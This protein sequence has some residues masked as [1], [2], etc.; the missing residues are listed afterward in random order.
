VIALA[1]MLIFWQVPPNVWSGMQPAACIKDGCFCEAANQDSPIKQTAN[2]IS[3]LGF[4]FSGMIVMIR[5]KE[6]SRFPQLYS[7]IIGVSSL[8]IGVGSAFYHA[9]LTFIGQ[10][11]D[12]FGMFL[13]A[14][15]L[16]VYAF[17]RI[18][19]LRITTTL[20]LY[21]TLNL[22]LSWIQIAIPETRRYAFAI[23]LIIALL[24]ERYY[25]SKMKPQIEAKWLRYGIIILAVAY[26]IWIADNTRMI[27]FEH[28]I[29]QGH[30]IWHILGAVSVL[31][32]H[33]YY[34]SER[35]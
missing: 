17:E 34:V 16:L 12:V 22:I 9:S 21:L 19:N 2:T 28:S 26:I 25:R 8:I 11:F 10:F 14:A 1:A 18:W 23:V 27:C 35:N 29:I 4:V 7:I 15:F 20:S 3:S 5:R 6:L 31:F 33:W 24:F 30:A 13:L 32:L